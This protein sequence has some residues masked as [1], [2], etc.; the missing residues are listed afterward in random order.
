VCFVFCFILTTLRWLGSSM[1]NLA[2]GLGLTCSSTTTTI[3]TANRPNRKVI[4]IDRTR[5]IIGN[6]PRRLTLSVVPNPTESRTS[7]LTA[8][9]AYTRR[10]FLHDWLQF[11]AIC[12]QSGE[13][14]DTT[15]R[16]VDQEIPPWRSRIQSKVPNTGSGIVN[17]D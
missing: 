7:F 15:A 5:T 3:T 9:A 17:E 2:F 8:K 4:G 11:P 12:P 14:P 13:P 6:I 16:L 10:P 1:P